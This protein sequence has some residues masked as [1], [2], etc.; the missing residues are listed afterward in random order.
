M[1]FTALHFEVE[2]AEEKRAGPLGQPPRDRIASLSTL[3]QITALR[4]H[5]C[6]ALS[7]DHGA[8]KLRAK[9]QNATARTRNEKRTVTTKPKS[10]THVLSQRCYLCP[11]WACHSSISNFQ[12]SIEFPHLPGSA[13]P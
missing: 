8:G 1:S 12:S 9:I 11:D 2:R 4:L 10:V 13:K 7:S 6:R 3:G 5:S